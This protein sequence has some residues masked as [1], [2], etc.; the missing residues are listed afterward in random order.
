M[1]LGLPGASYLLALDLLH[2]QGLGAGETVA[3]VIAF[4]LVSLMLIELPL[5]GFTLAPDRTVETIERFKAWIA[6]DGRQ[7]GTTAALVVGLL[8]LARAA[9]E[10]FS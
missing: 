5:L 6:R 8:L 9:I 1:L 2:K 7:V 10:F 3:S 4:C